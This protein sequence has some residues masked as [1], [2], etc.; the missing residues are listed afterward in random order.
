MGEVR[1]RRVWRQGGAGDGAGQLAHDVFP[2]GA[3]VGRDVG[4]GGSQVIEPFVH[5]GEHR[6]LAGRL[7]ERD[8]EQR[9]EGRPVPALGSHETPAEHDA[10]AGHQLGQLA[11]EPADL[12]PGARVPDPEAPAGPLVDLGPG[13]GEGSRRH[14]LGQQFRVKPCPVDP[15]RRCRNG[16][17]QPD[18]QALIGH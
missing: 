2:A 5:E 3:D 16:A 4:P 10:V 14:P 11:V 12:P 6:C 8:R 18:N 15:L 1:D 13:D 7:P 9:I 17:F